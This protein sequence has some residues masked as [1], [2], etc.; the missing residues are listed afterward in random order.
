MGTWT[1]VAHVAKDTPKRLS[2][3]M[4][5]TARL[6]AWS[7]KERVGTSETASESCGDPTVVA[8][9]S[10]TRPIEASLVTRFMN[11]Y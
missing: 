1:T 5:V 7:E 3:A 10:R 4:A 9:R 11:L 2:T 8:L 6:T